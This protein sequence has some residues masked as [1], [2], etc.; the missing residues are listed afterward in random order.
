MSSKNIYIRK[1]I[2][3][4]LDAVMKIIQSCTNDMISQK[5]FQWND[6]YPDRET[7]FNDIENEDLLLLVQDNQLL[8]CVSVTNKMDDF[9]ST[10]DWIAATK[11]NIYVHRLAIHPKYQGLGYAKRI[12]NYIENDA[13]ENNYNSIRLDTFS[14]NKK[15]NNFYSNIGYEKLGQIYF[16]DQSDMPFNC[17]EKCLK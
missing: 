4:D 9:Y 1:A 13:I 7:F 5:I 2:Q 10:I 16:R 12:M 17:Y 6:K 3:G 11:K 15:N 8:G 14:M